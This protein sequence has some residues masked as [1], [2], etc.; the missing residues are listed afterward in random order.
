MTR[1]QAS[2]PMNTFVRWQFTV[3]GAM[4]VGYAA[5]MLCRNTLIAS[6]A[7]LLND[8]SL[9]MDKESFGH[10]MSWHSAGAICGKLVHCHHFPFGV[11]YFASVLCPNEHFCSVIRG[12]A[13]RL[14][15]FVN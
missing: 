1:D 11:K 12:Q 4:Y 8:P 15:R 13:F 6:S 9:Q 14:P 3:L 7:A 10:L 2:Q 5:F